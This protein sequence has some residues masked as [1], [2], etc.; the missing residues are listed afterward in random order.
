M[1][2][3]CKVGSPFCATCHKFYT[4]CQLWC[5]VGDILRIRKLQTT[6]SFGF[7]KAHQEVK[8]RMQMHNSTGGKKAG[9]CGMV[10]KGG[11]GSG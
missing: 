7:R 10:G 8:V 6:G 5:T 9:K 1:W 4:C 3:V 2:D 11:N